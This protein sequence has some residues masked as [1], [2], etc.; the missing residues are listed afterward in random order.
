[1]PFVAGSPGT[2]SQALQ[3]AAVDVA[4]LQRR[5]G[6][7]LAIG[8][9]VPGVVPNCHAYLEIWPVGLRTYNLLVPNFLNL[10]FLLFGVGPPKATVGFISRRRWRHTCFIH[11]WPMPSAGSSSCER[12]PL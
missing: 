2:L 10:P 4:T 7:Q 8:R 1:M 6:P 5:Y 3:G 11:V 12:A 9:K